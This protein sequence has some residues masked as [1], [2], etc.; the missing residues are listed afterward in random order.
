MLA[1][2][3]PTAKALLA[4]GEIGILLRT[5]ESLAPPSSR[6]EAS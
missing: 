4:A 5:V 6:P 3:L 1:P 2:W